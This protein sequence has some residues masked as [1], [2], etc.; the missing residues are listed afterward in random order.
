MKKIPSKLQDISVLKTDW[1]RIIN[2]LGLS[3]QA[4]EFARNL[5]IYKAEH[6]MVE[7]LIAPSLAPLGD[8]G[9]SEKVEKALQER[10]GSDLICMGWVGPP[11]ESKDQG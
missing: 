2:D 4:R 5:T 11:P 1:H 8:N 9:A 3:G 6:G 10:F 7:F